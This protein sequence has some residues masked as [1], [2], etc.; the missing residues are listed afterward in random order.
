MAL[1]GLMRD[2]LARVVMTKGT[3][4]WATQSKHT[5]VQTRWPSP[6]PSPKPARVCQ[7]GQWPSEFASTSYTLLA[8][9][10]IEKIVMEE[11]NSLDERIEWVLWEM[12]LYNISINWIKLMEIATGRSPL[13]SE[14]L[15]SSLKL[16]ILVLAILVLWN[17]IWQGTDVSDWVTEGHCTL[18]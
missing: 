13:V 1:W 5:T 3:A 7:V 15:L 17:R 12:R 9:V 2:A 4:I 11:K 10:K 6:Y 16:Y 14:T 18:T 8:L